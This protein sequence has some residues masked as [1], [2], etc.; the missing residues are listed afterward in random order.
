MALNVLS[1][2]TCGVLKVARACGVGDKN[3]VGDN[4]QT[5]VVVALRIEK[6]DGENKVT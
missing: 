3:S 4:T 2:C 1:Q 6:C 5:L